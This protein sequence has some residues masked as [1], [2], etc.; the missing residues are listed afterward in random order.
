M[1][2]PIRGGGIITN[3]GWKTAA[4]NDRKAAVK[5]T[6]V[7]TDWL[8]SSKPGFESYLHTQVLL[9]IR[10]TSNS[11]RAVQQEIVLFF[12]ALLLDTVVPALALPIFGLKISHPFIS[13]V[14]C[15][16]RRN[17]YEFV[18]YCSEWFSCGKWV[19]GVLGGFPVSRMYHNVIKYVYCWSEQNIF[20]SVR[21]LAHHSRTKSRFKK[22]KA[23]FYWFISD[24]LSS[25]FS[26]WGKQLRGGKL[27]LTIA[28][29]FIGVRQWLKNMICHY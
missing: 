4:D 13:G 29:L 12:S 5:I 18:S 21:I 19:K 27:C 28:Y 23:W 16:G 1:P 3:Y 2:L 11:N 10:G 17:I 14:W 26:T 24:F 22:I 20:V 6:V 9:D 25:S 8:S 7:I 15:H